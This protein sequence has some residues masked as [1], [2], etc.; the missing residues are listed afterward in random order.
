M[1]KNIRNIFIVA[2]FTVFGGWLG[3]WLN[4]VT[5]NTSPP[6]QSLGALVWL[7]SPA[8]TGFFVRAVGGD[9]WKD[10]GF[11]LNLRTSWKYYLLAIFI[12]PLASLLTFI[13]GLPFGIISTDGFAEQGFSAYFSLVGITFVG[14]LVKNFFEEFAWRSYFTPRLDAIKMHPI[15][16]HFITGVLWW[17]WHLPY[18]YYFLDKT[19]L[20]S[21]TTTS[22]PVFLLLAFIVQ[23]PTAILFGELRLLSK[24]TWTVF[25]LHNIINAISLPLFINGFIEAKGNLAVTFSPTND[26]LIVALIF[27]I[28][29]WM[30]YQHRMKNQ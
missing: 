8:L 17:S 20:E 28:V 14:S 9:G 26:G 22:F 3:I 13:L 24:S 4:N 7:T 25:L 12:Y 15:L 1:N 30:L 2:F 10:A 21:A 16:N 11:G 5:G 29:G 19:I 6:L 27:G 18:Y 23:F